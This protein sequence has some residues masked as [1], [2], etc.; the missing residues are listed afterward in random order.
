MLSNRLEFGEGADLF[1]EY[2]ASCCQAAD[3]AGDGAVAPW[4]RLVLSGDRYLRDAWDARGGSYANKVTAEG[5][6]GFARGLEAAR[7]DLTESWRL[8][9]HRP[10]AAALMISVAIGQGT[11]HGPEGTRAWFDR[12]VRAEVDYLHA[13]NSFGQSLL[14]QW[15]GSTDTV[16]AFGLNCASTDAYDTDVPWQINAA[17][18][19][20]EPPGYTDPR[21]HAAMER[22]FAGYEAM[23]SQV[24]RRVFLHNWHARVEEL[25]GQYADAYRLMKEVN[26]SLS[27][28]MASELAKN[29]ANSNYFERIAAY[30]GAGGAD[31]QAGDELIARGHADQALDRL[32]AALTA[33]GSDPRATSY[34]QSR[35][36]KL[37]AE[38]QLAGGNWISF[39]PTAGVGGVPVGWTSKLGTWRVAADG[40][41][42]GQAGAS[43]L[44]LVNDV[45]VGTDFEI[46]GEFDFLP[47][48]KS[49]EQTGVVF[50]HPDMEN[51][52]WQSFRLK[53]NGPDG[54]IATISCHWYDGPKRPLTVPNNN[55]FALQSWHG[56]IT[57]TINGEVVFRAQGLDKGQ[58]SDGS[59]LVGLGGYAH[60]GN[61]FAVS[62]RKLQLRRLTS[63]PVAQN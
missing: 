25:N 34:L 15:Y 61:P 28:D 24:G 54:A 40:A 46:R 17:L 51:D 26:W 2:R 30:G 18:H 59:G 27:P 19:S 37:E 21:A 49:E 62:Y 29:P 3:E 43:G 58:V 60:H 50:G 11:A 45:Q 48:A 39:Q 36:S 22:V 31:A 33:E 23:P 55:V 13:Y 9:P 57:L 6:R 47:G 16:L 7:R 1:G 8:N 10:E 41:L 53:R 4:L 52:D 14:P 42:V 20:M 35:I 63:T 44:M 12:A 32:R 38:R 56:L 5:W